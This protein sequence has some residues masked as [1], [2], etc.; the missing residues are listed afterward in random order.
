M[1]KGLLKFG[2]LGSMALFCI[3][4]DGQLFRRSPDQ[5]FALVPDNWDDWF[6]FKTTYVLY[7]LNDDGR[8]VY[9]G[10]V[11]VG[12]F[13][14]KLDTP[15]PA[16][17][18]TFNALT[19]KFFSVGQDD[20][21]YQNLNELGPEIRNRCLTGLQDLALNNE[22][23]AVALRED[24]TRISLLRSVT[25]A[26]VRGQ[27]ARMA[28]GGARLTPFN[29]KYTTPL[30]KRK[31]S[32]MVLTFNVDPASRPPTNVHVIVGRNGVGKTHLMQ[33][34]TRCL[35]QPSVDEDL[36]HFEMLSDQAG[37][38]GISG[39]VSVSFSA[40]D[41]FDPIP[42]RRDKT[43][44]EIRYAYIGLKR[45]SSPNTPVLIPKSPNALATEFGKS[46][47]VCRHGARADR[48]RSA[49]STLEADPMFAAADVASLADTSLD[50]EV[51]RLQARSVFKRLSSGHKIVL[52]T[53]TR[54]VETVEERT[55]VLLDEPEAHLHP[56]LL[57]AFV[58]ALSD[59]LTDRNGIAIV[60]THSPVVL[61]E[62]PC[63]CVTIIRRAGAFST[64]T[65]PEV[66]TFGENA[67]VLTQQIFGLE[68]TA[69]G[70]HRLLSEAVAE[71][72][73]YSDVL[74]RFNGQ[75][76]SEGR[77]ILRALIASRDVSAS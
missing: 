10:P 27:F 64:A 45:T 2:Y 7:H 19:R 70:F 52:L 26:T 17:P 33:H 36:G 18:T 40:F 37:D 55:L 11:K 51:V 39:V 72:E 21:Y 75:I 41:E 16:L 43:K 30:P 4:V 47:A 77:S 69:S 12:Q 6:R 32:P 57:S 31:A 14:M 54:L 62:V 49:L 25:E 74:S 56:P 38:E 1:P 67:G 50:D 3:S 59:L 20:S 58:R 76:G 15:R 66:E 5:R 8:S 24:V 28:T 60:A 34:L 48:W 61:Q 42:D 44:K 35:A 22:G 63:S 46:V 53:V 9:V 65:R 68:V 71:G 13:R 73:T 23:I 29:F